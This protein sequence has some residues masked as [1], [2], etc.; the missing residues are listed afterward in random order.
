MGNLV[1]QKQDSQGADLK[2]DRLKESLDN[3]VKST[4]GVVD[5]VFKNLKVN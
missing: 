1:Q 3:V 2:T 5:S 4:S